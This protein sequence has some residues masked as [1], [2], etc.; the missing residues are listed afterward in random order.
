VRLFN[1]S[2]V[3]RRDE[4]QDLR[5]EKVLQ[6]LYYHFPVMSQVIEN[7][8]STAETEKDGQTRDLAEREEY[9]INYSARGSLMGYLCPGISGRPARS[10]C[11]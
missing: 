10:Q 6:L 8:D 4:A 11:L 3:D 7:P 2:V 1:R 5:V 9:D